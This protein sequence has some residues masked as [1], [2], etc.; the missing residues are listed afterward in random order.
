[1]DRLTLEIEEDFKK[2]IE[3]HKINY[4]YKTLK[5]F[6]ITAINNQ[7]KNDKNNA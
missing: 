5:D 1:M 2:T 6:V 7:I 4:G 3:I